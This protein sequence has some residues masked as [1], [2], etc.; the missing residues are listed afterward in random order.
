[1]TK[2]TPR[3]LLNFKP[4]LSFAGFA[5]TNTYFVSKISFASSPVCL[6]IV[7]TLLEVI[8]KPQIRLK[9]KAQADEKAQHTRQY[10]SILKRLATRLLGL[11]WGFK[12]TSSVSL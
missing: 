4:V 3:V 6:A 10:V 7:T 11:R 8:L 9:S 1:M 5:F 2:K 12:T